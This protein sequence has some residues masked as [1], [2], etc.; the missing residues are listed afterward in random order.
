VGYVVGVDI[1]GTFTDCIAI[2]SGSGDGDGASATADR[3][4]IGK[5]PS[6]PPD[7]HNGFIDAMRAA[8]KSL[9][10]DLETL[11]A[12]TDALYHGCTVG[13]NALVEGRTAKVGLVTTRG[14]RDTIF[15]MQAGGRLKNL[16][17]EYIA[18]VSMQDKPEPLV[19]KSLCGEIDERIAFDGEVLVE[20][21]EET[22]R[23]EVR[24]LVAAGVEAFAISLLWSPVND[25]HE[26]RLEELIAEEAPGAFISRAS[27]VVPRTGEYERTVATVVNALIGPEMDRY[28][29]RLGT[30][31]EQVGSRHPVQIMTC[32]GGVI[33]SSLARSIPVLTIGSGPVAGLIGAG[34][35][36]GRATPGKPANVIT[37][38]MGGTSFDVGVV[39]GGVPLR[40][41]SSNYG[42]YEYFVPTLDVRSVG[43]GGGSIIRFDEDAQTLRVGPQSAGARP[44]PACYHQGGERPTITD[45]NLVLGY[46]NPD[47]FL[48]GNIA[49]DVGAART[50]LESAGAPLG[51]DAEQTAAAAVRIVDNAMADVIRLASVQQG[52]DPR[53]F[54][55]YAFGGAGP[56]H[57]SAL[58]RELGIG[59]VVV[60]L[61]NF[62]AGWS[63]FGIASSDVVVVKEI[64]V[65]LKHPFD[66]ELLNAHWQ[67]LEEAVREEMRRQDI[68]EPAIQIHRSVE[69]RY[70]MQVNEVEVDAADGVYDDAAVAAL[71]TDFESEYE[72]L[73]GKGSGYADAGFAMTGLR[74]LGSA[75]MSDFEIAGS[76][77][78]AS[79]A[80]TEKGRRP[81]LWDEGGVRPTATPVYDGTTFLPG[82]EVD[83]PA[84]VEYPDTTI[85]LRGGDVASLDGQGSVLVDLGDVGRD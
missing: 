49:L 67:A 14:H 72:R 6:T 34:G 81:V 9:G 65:G 18:R 42:Q 80:P 57:S 20:L 23:T 24:R 70:A 19:P 1:G 8:A 74:V 17:P 75:S 82:M 36:A 3:V 55:L 59:R 16:P 50:A 38:D 27:E 37:G 83:G 47:Y 62:A 79:G 54:A 40:R 28:L 44:G 21:N 85:V 76:D 30:E 73:Y 22:A 7:F 46:L 48:G 13:T 64:S 66:P 43:A 68:P 25:V 61:S 78:Q 2:D 29:E 12:D 15:A 84:I 35:L 56:V 52:Y 4:A 32:T 69:M 39:S 53:D 10:T 26:K 51:F 77:R 58:A 63:A 71:I 33:G 5:A 60:P 31:L 11:M 45:A 41:S